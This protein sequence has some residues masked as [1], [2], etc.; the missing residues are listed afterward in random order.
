MKLSVFFDL[1][2]I[3]LSGAVAAVITVIEMWWRADPWMLQMIE[4]LCVK[5]LRFIIAS[6]TITEAVVFVSLRETD[7]KLTCH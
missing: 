3:A 6:I 4:D 1:T 5:T 2:I 7:V